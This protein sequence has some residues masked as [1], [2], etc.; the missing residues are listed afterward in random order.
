[1][2]KIDS[3]IA[4]LFAIQAFS[5]DIHY[6]VKGEAFYS[7]HLLADEIYKGIDE[8]IFYDTA[9]DFKYKQV[10]IVYK[11]KGE[12][13]YFLVEHQTKVDYSMPYRILK[14]EVEIIESVIIDKKCTPT[15]FEED[16]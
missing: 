10:D 1:M 9:K 5:K 14:Y 6:S 12:E 3:L 7:K 4:Y 16:F 11:I 2:N 13:I 15:A 8:Q